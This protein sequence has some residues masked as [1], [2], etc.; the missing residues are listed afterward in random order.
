M[1]IQLTWQRA[2]TLTVNTDTNI[3]IHCQSD[4]LLATMTGSGIISGT[5][6]MDTTT[7]NPLAN[8]GNATVARGVKVTLV[9]NPGGACR[10]S[11][12]Q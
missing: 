11:S 4:S 9:Q 5:I 12:Y 6:W 8:P 10:V 7:N 2:K 1:V 3:T